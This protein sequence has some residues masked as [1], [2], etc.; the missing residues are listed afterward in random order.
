MSRGGPSKYRPDIVAKITDAL[1]IHATHRLAGDYAGIDEST[2]SAWLLKYPEFRQAV[3]E[4]EG[5]AG[6][7]CLAT[8]HKAA[9]ESWQAAAWLMERRYP[10]QY[11][12]TV[13]TQDQRS[14]QVNLTPE[15]LAAMSDAELD[16]LYARLGGGGTGAAAKG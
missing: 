13:Q 3:R 11:G 6:I 16:A 5:R 10:D 2:F 8:I 12:R 14:M 1:A 7:K 15:Q 4:A 9:P